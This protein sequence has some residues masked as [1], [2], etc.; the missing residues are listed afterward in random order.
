MTFHGE[1]LG[2][3]VPTF[4]AECYEGATA[5]VVAEHPDRAVAQEIADRHA[6]TCDMCRMYSIRAYAEFDIPEVNMSNNNAMHLM[7]R[8][9]VE[10]GDGCGAMDAAEFMDRLGFAQVVGGGDAGSDT[11][12]VTGGGGPTITYCGRSPGYTDRRLAELGEVGAWAL[13]RQRRVVWS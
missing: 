11:F 2:T 1:I 6:L 3:D 5:G 4:R 8:L 9:G 10:F 13:A 7:D 12:T